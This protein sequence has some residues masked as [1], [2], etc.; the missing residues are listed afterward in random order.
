[1]RDRERG[2][3]WEETSACRGFPESGGALCADPA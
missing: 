3:I 2:V 1:M